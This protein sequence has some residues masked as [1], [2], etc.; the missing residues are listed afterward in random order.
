M[1]RPVRLFVVK[2]KDF[3]TPVSNY[4]CLNNKKEEIRQIQFL[5]K[6]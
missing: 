4:I 6:Q 1:S 2:K 3:R 5:V